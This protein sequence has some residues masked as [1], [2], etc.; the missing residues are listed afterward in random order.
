[1]E[2]PK[3]PKK[4]IIAI[5]VIILIFLFGA[6]YL[7]FNFIS[8]NSK[9]GVEIA[10]EFYSKLEQ[11]DYQEILNMPRT[12]GGTS[13]NETIALFAGIN[14]KLGD[15]VSYQLMRTDV[16]YYTNV[17]TVITLDYVVNRTVYNTNERLIILKE[18]GS[19]KYLLDLYSADS[20]EFNK[21]QILG[22]ISN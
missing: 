14:E 17:G 13:D 4:K 7:F 1:M 9:V 19:N 21:N 12:P 10:N 22:D 6:L 3:K 16:H 8:K 2:K 20:P 18:K 5:V 11:K 15:I